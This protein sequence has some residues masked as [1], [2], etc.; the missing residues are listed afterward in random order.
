T[1]VT[2]RRAWARRRVLVSL[3]RASCFLP[4]RWRQ[5]AWVAALTWAGIAVGSA[6]AGP[7][8]C[9]APPPLPQVWSLDAAVGWALHYNPELAAVRQQHGIAAAGIV[10]ARTYPFNPVYETRQRGAWGPPEAGVTAHYPQD[11]LVLLELEVCGQRGHRISQAQA[12][13]TRT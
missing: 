6:A 2:L 4:G 3:N 8:A 11:H 7:P 10:I 5:I 13:L 1:A 12:A 9:F